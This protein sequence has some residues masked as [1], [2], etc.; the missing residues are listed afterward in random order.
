[1][2]CSLH[3]GPCLRETT[4]IQEMSMMNNSAG[5]TECKVVHVDMVQ[6]T[7]RTNQAITTESHLCPQLEHSILVCEFMKIS[8]I[9]DNCHKVIYKLICE[10][11]LYIS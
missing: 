6:S 7:L 1:M 4:L 2:V 8:V 5:L 9:V 10:L 11:S 3:G